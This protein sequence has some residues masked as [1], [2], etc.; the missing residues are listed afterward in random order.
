MDENFYFLE[1]EKLCHSE[2][3]EEYVKEVERIGRE[4]AHRVAETTLDDGRWVSTVC[5]MIDH[6][7]GDGPP[8]VFETMVFPSRGE[9]SEIY[10]DR[11]STYEAAFEGHKSVVAAFSG[12]AKVEEQ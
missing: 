6:N 4:K 8:V 9:L 10:M 5:L 12:N 1:N 7:W 2:T 3:I 11:Y